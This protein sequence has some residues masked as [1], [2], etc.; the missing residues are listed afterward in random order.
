MYY[1]LSP[2]EIVVKY[3]TPMW[4]DPSL[5]WQQVEKLIPHE[6]YDISRNIYKYDIGLIRLKEE[7]A[8]NSRVQ[9]VKLPLND[10]ITSN[11]TAVITGWGN[12]NVSTVVVCYYHYYYFITSIS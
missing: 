11:V 9:P 7:I 4:N 10:K 1:Y 8:F 3:G 2:I 6:D 5:E 12:L